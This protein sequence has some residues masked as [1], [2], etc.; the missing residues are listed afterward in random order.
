MSFG[1]PP[2]RPC[3]CQPRAHAHT[4]TV[5]ASRAHGLSDRIQRSPPS[6]GG[7]RQSGRPASVCIPTFFGVYVANV[8]RGLWLAYRRRRGLEREDQHHKDPRGDGR[9]RVE[10]LLPREPCT[11]RMHDAGGGKK[12]ASVCG[13]AKGAS[14]ADGTERRGRERGRRCATVAVEEQGGGCAPAPS[15]KPKTMRMTASPSM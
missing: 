4:H 12:V 11:P 6:Q 14:R 10:Q 8:A 7:A 3:L 1:S 13:S 5:L 2:R 15:T 9:G